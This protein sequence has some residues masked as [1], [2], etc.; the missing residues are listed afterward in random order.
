MPT[1]TDY[2][3]EGRADE[4]NSAHY[5][6]GLGSVGIASPVPWKRSVERS[7]CEQTLSP[8]AVGIV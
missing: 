8:G 3:A 6:S 7:R 2:V 1:P 5:L 4:V